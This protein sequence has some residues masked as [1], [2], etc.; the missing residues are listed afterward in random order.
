MAVG[1]ET[2]SLLLH[3]TSVVA[4]VMAPPIRHFAKPPGVMR[5][6]PYCGGMLRHFISEINNKA[7]NILRSVDYGYIQ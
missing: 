2:G 4:Q 1:V 6:M 7:E 3:L 5:H